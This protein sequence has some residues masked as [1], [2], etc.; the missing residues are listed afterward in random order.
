MV[1]CA[2]DLWSRLLPFCVSDFPVAMLRPSRQS[3]LGSRSHSGV[4]LFVLIL[5]FAN[6]AIAGDTDSKKAA[7]SAAELKA[8]TEQLNALDS[9]L[10]DADRKRVELQKELET[11][12]REVAAVS[13]RLDEANAAAASADAALAALE[14]DAASLREVRGRQARHIAGHLSAAHRLAGEDF[15]KLM[16]NQESPETFDRMIRYHRYFSAAR[17]QT[18]DDYRATLDRLA[19]NRTELEAQAATAAALRTEREERQAELFAGQEERKAVIARLDEEAQDKS[20]E[21]DRLRKDGAR[22]ETLV[23]EL[24]RKA[25]K[26]DGKT[27][28]QAR[29]KLPWPVSGRVVHAFGAPR[30]EGRLSWDGILVAADQGATFRAVHGGQVVFADWLRGFGLMTIVDHGSGYMTLYGQADALA[31]KVGDRVQGGDVLGRAGSSGGQGQT[32]V[33]FEVRQK[34]IARD[35]AAWLGPR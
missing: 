20:A 8:I 12:D 4:L 19:A 9:W 31:R 24:E 25:L 23:A 29:G 34:G 35:P 17:L 7:A 21:R 33:Y 6:P 28:A 22:L 30:A 1:P 3:R 32:G 16:L 13:A 15:F 14:A 26:L 27:F 2:S 18:L 10:G 11:N 5:C